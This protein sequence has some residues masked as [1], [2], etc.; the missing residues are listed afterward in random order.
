MRK[1]IITGC[2]RFL[3]FL[4]VLV[5]IVSCGHMPPAGLQPPAHLKPGAV[6]YGVV[7]PL[8]G[9]SPLRD[10]TAK[11]DYLQEL[12]VDVLWLSPIHATDDP[13]SISY[14]I[15]DY[16]GL[17]SDF[18]DMQDLRHLVNEAHRR[19]LRVMMDFV[20]NHT[21]VEH[22]YYMDIQMNGANSIYYDFYDRDGAGR[23]T[24]Y[25]D[26]VGLPNLNYDHPEVLS[27]MTLAFK[28]WILAAGL[29][30]YRVDVA[31][32]IRER[33]PEVWHPLIRTLRAIDPQVI[34]LAEAPARDP[35]YIHNG[36]DL[37]YDW[38][39]ELG[40]WAWKPAFDHLDEAG[41]RL[42]LAIVTDQ[43]APQTVLR[44][45]NNNDTGHRF[46]SRYGRE[47]T[48]VAAVLQHMVPGVP[49][50]YTGDEV[51]AEYEPYEDPPPISWEDTHG[52]RD[53]YRT[54]AALRE[55][56]P[57]IHSGA[58]IPLPP[59]G[60]PSAYAFVRVADRKNW[61]LVVVNFGPQGQA[62]LDL[63]EAVADLIG[64][65]LLKEELSDSRLIPAVDESGTL[66][67]ALDAF[68][69][70]ILTPDR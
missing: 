60:N 31:W 14:S 10:V 42:H 24:H 65:S 69:A 26:W 13:S 21:S 27:D 34:M 28:Y 48:R 39:E 67:I 29:D 46:I 41:Q 38:T 36:F 12:G 17:R 6:I 50:V 70:M 66:K 56:L 53:L 62:V 57:A 51:G 4:P 1:I 3:R 44:F 45:L 25:F 37:A 16:F 30:G 64:D 32:G 58:F 49:L 68:E 22:P 33:A 59:V 63:P 15:T 2:D 47:V 11:L 52:L 19:G 18:G 8:F 9:G 23:I 7:P 43:A 40:H 20:P 61:A 35:Y 5:F 54:L 55:E